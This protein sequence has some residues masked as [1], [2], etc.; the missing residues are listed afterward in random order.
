MRQPGDIRG[1][2]PAADGWA[3]FK[4]QQRLDFL[5][6]FGDEFCDALENAV[7]HETLVPQDGF[8]VFLRVFQAEP[9]PQLLASL[10][11]DQLETFRVESEKYFET[12]GIALEQIRKV[13]AHTLAR[14]PI[15]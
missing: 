11:D 15:Q 10:S 12:E 7:E 4:H 14:C 1:Q 5:A 8:E 13:V 2:G 9:T 6:A 3:A